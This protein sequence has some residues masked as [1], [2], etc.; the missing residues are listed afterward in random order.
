[1]SHNRSLQEGYDRVAEEYVH[2]I[3]N[4]LDGKPFD[5]VQLDALGNKVGKLGPICDLG[6][7]PG[8]VA[9]YLK[10]AGF[11]NVVGVDLS[12]EMISQARR[13]NP[14]I[15]FHQGDMTHLDI[16]DGAWG[17]I[18]AFYSIIHI[19]RE[20]IATCFRELWRVLRDR[21]V[22][23][24][25]FHIGDQTVHLDEWWGHPVSL[26]F[27]FL[28]KED[29]ETRLRSAGFIIESFLERNPYRPDIEHQS[30]RGYVF[31]RKI[32]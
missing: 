20:Q 5:R 24:L 29:I 7:G 23:L 32:T 2:R 1:M 19:P 3:F 26:D 11:E 16:P 6:C 8:Q 31:A 27:N 9:R 12:S 14:D 28:Q 18:A 22:L 10:D 30:R 25:S 13:L 21:G 17:G 15:V 4:E